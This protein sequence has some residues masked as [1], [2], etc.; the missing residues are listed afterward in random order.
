MV[1]SLWLPV[2]EA[3]SLSSDSVGM[4]EDDRVEDEENEDSS[5]KDEASE[6]KENNEGTE[7][8]VGK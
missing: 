4:V 3:D 8:R 1:E 6:G 2:D 7:V 5:S